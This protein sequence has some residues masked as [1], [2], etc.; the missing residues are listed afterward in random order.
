MAAAHA[1]ASGWLAVV[2][3][4]LVA[5]GLIAVRAS[6]PP[7]VAFVPTDHPW[8]RL[9]REIAAEFGMEQPVLWVL[10]ARAGSAWTPAV[11]GRLQALT[12]DVLTIPGV[13][14]TDVVSLASP[15]L[16]DLHVTEDRLE[17]IY[18]MRDVP[19]SEGALAALRRRVESDPNY[20][21]TLVSLD[22]RAAMVVANFRAEADP[23]AVGRAAVALRDRYTDATTAAYVTGAPVLRVTAPAAGRAAMLP[24]IAVAGGMLLVVALVL[25]V[26]AATAA[27]LAAA[28][29]MLWTVAAMLGIGVVVLPW[30]AFALPPVAAVAAGLVLTGA[31]ASS[32]LVAA[33]ASGILATAAGPPL[34]AFGAA[35]AIGM[36]AAVG[37][38]R[39]TARL[40]AAGAGPRTPSLRVPALLLAALA[41]AGLPRVRPAFDL[42]GYGERYLPGAAGRELVAVGRRFPPP[43]TLAL[44]VRGTPGFVAEPAVLH[45]LDD[46][47]RAAREDP[48]V[49]SAMS[50]ADVVRMVHRA[51]ND[52]DP[53]F[54][55]VPDDRGLVARYLTLAYSPGFRRFVDRG[56]SRTA[57]WVYLRSAAPGDVARVVAR[58]DA[59]LAAGPVPG[60]QVDAVG[61][62]GAAILLAA[63]IAR[64]LAVG[65]GLL[66]LAIAL[67]AGAL[68]GGR[69]VAG[70]LVG[71]AIAAIV[72]LGGCGWLGLGADLLAIPGLA[73]AVVAA[74]TLGALPAN[75][76][77]WCRRLALALGLAATLPLLAPL[78]AVRLA[79]V[80]LAATAAGIAAAARGNGVDGY[81]GAC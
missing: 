11:L 49:T 15:N 73:G 36:A 51:F 30:S 18:L 44:R 64:R 75:G 48:A 31:G 61:G 19:E 72:G 4:V 8:M 71:G 33:V 67:V 9:D 39:V 34:A 68:V 77:A 37:A 58:M 70:A 10:E 55:V 25:G 47:V 76:G 52:D 28:L 63:R 80:L 62:D 78:G 17:P 60:A 14:A 66:V 35:I 29:A 43:T 54:A 6:A 53:A 21:G 20:R 57:L 69:G 40:L 12:R 23:D 3:S 24:L 38:G 32:V 1:R 65:T 74:A 26:R 7:P 5:G 79:G 2:V 13:V 16:R 81:A 59:E 42:L 46:V 41:A 22:G 27:L 45:A 56:L 50:I